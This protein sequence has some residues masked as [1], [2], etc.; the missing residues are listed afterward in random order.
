MQ[1]AESFLLR[2][3]Q[4]SASLNHLALRRV[5]E[6]DAITGGEKRERIRRW[7]GLDEV[8]DCR[9]LYRNHECGAVRCGAV[10]CG[11]FR[12]MGEEI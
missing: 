12:T 9:L 1:P 8:V 5:E 11:G 6:G 4:Y 7:F 2:A 10:R 3:A